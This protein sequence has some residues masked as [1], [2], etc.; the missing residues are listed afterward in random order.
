MKAERARL[1]WI[2]EADYDSLLKR[3]RFAPIGSVWFQGKVGEHFAETMKRRRAEIGDEEH[4][5]ASK[6]VGWG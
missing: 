6:R 3:W 4:T 5:A 1:R 2:D